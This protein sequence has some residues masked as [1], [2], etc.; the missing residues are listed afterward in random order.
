MGTRKGR[1]AWHS[2]PNV[3]LAQRGVW[4]VCVCGGLL[5]RGRGRPA[6]HWATAA[7]Q[8]CALSRR[9]NGDLCTPVQA[10]PHRRPCLS[11]YLPSY[12]YLGTYLLLHRES[13]SYTVAAGPV[14]SA[15]LLWVTR[16][17]YRL[18][19]VRCDAVYPRTRYPRTSDDPSCGTCHQTTH[20]QSH[21][22]HPCPMRSWK[23]L[24][25]MCRSGLQVPYVVCISRSR[26]M[27]AAGA[28]G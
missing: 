7:K 2:K 3:V 11:A 25:A 27:H 9:D 18:C 23:R 5:C 26:V 4:Y 12:L 6:V 1:K 14:G 10:R 16:V 8:C 28:I 15:L 19:A 22:P 20:P 17:L 24:A 13:S 21:A